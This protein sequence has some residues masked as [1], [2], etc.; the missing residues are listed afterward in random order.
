MLFAPLYLKKNADRRLRIGHVWI[1]SNEVDTDRSPLNSFEIGQAITIYAHNNKIL[2]NG[3]INPHSLICARLISRDPQYHLDQSLLLQ[4]LNSALSLRQ[5]L[6]AKP[7]Y[8]LV[9][10]ESD[11][12]PGLVVDRFGDIVVVQIT[13]AGMERVREEVIAALTTTLHPQAIVL[14]NDTAVRTLEGLENYVAVVQGQLPAEVLIEENQAH[15]YVSVLEG[16]KTGWFYDHRYNRARLK[17]YAQQQR[18]LDVFSYSGAWSIPAALA[19]AHSVWCI[20][21]SQQALELVKKNSEL[22]QVTAKVHPLLGDAFEQLKELHRAGEK[23]DLIILDPPAF[24]KRKKDQLAGEQAYRRIN[25]LAMQLLPTEGILISASCSLHLPSQTLLDLLRATS[26]QLD[27]GLQILEQGHQSPDH[28][29]H[30]AIPETAYI[31]AFV[32]RV[33]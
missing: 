13:T 12:L 16:Q 29:I 26:Q 3:Y 17:H 10:G 22:N 11:G 18:V 28:P 30:P 32:C 7:F 19:G 15:F 6:F 9:Y 33:L 21:S 31:K 25:Q 2:G 20:D 1:Y 8:R 23:F 14:R 27:R 24:I 5:R 4:R